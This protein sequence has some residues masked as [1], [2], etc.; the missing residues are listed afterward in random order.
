MKSPSK[1]NIKLQSAY[2]IN[3][4]DTYDEYTGLTKL[5]LFSLTA[6]QSLIAVHPEEDVKVI[7]TK[8]MKYATSL[9]TLL[10]SKQSTAT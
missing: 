6:M 10:A 2:P 7:A 9:L 8:S 3:D 5:E 1:V 4:L